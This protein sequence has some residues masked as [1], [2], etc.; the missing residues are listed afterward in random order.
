MKKIKYFFQ[1]VMR[2]SIVIVL[3]LAPLFAYVVDVRRYVFDVW[4]IYLQWWLVLPIYFFGVIILLFLACLF[5]GMIAI[6]FIGLAKL[7]RLLK[8]IVMLQKGKTSK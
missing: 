4:G 3:F 8:R 5:I 6:F 7:F 1:G 2:E